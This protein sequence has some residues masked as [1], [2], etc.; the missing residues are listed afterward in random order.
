MLEVSALVEAF[1]SR[2]DA[3]TGWRHLFEKIED[4]LSFL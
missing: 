1:I 4:L 2:K 3:L